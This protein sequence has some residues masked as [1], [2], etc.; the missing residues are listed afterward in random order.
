MKRDKYIE[1]QEIIRKNQVTYLIE[2]QYNVQIILKILMNFSLYGGEEKFETL[3]RFFHSMK[4][5]AATFQLQDLAELGDKY[6]KFMDYFGIDEMQKPDKLGVLLQALG[7]ISDYIQKSIIEKP[8]RENKQFIKE[9]KTMTYTG[10]LLIVDDDVALLDLME[11]LFRNEGYHVFISS[12]PDEVISLVK[13]ET[14]DLIIMDIMMPNKTGFDLYQQMKQEN[15]D[16]PTIFLTGTEN[17]ESRIKALREGIDHYIIKPFEPEEL[18]ASVEGILKKKNQQQMQVIKDDLTGAYVRRYFNE[19]FNKEKER[20]IRNGKSLA[21]A[22]LD[23]DHFKF[24]NDT[25]G[26]TFGDVILKGFVYSLEKNLRE[27]DMVFRYGG[28]EFL[29]LF[30][31]TDGEE[32]YDITERIRSIIESQPYIPE[33]GN[34]EIFISFSAGIAMLQHENMTIKELLDKADQALYHS[35]EMGRGKTTY[36]FNKRKRKKKLLIVDD[37]PIMGNLIK[38]RFLSLGYEVDYA[39]DGVEALKKIDVFQPNIVFLDLMLPK[40]N[41]FEVLKQLQEKKN[42]HKMKIIVISSKNQEEDMLKCL[43]LGANDY[44]TKPFSLEM[45]EE[46]AKRL[47]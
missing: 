26:H 18:F 39:K 32:A 25:Y 27:Y 46:R 8:I 23:I 11:K 24:I 6:E 31:A 28:D 4:G 33:G 38:T 44:I 29:I 7:Q 14:F 19:K 21:I 10:K 47:L 36:N 22:F 15:I 13:E 41:G 2:Q 1:L 5:T 34:E 45:L 20:Y 35:K 30:P 9:Y 17:K 16:I 42:L 3:K 40:L 37:V 43:R 12:N